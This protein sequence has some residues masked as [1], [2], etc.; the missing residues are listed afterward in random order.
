MKYKINLKAKNIELSKKPLSIYRLAQESDEKG[1]E[2][3]CMFYVNAS[4]FEH[5]DIST[6]DIYK[7]AID[8]K[9][10]VNTSFI[11]NLNRTDKKLKQDI[12][13][14]FSIAYL[15]SFY[16]ICDAITKKRNTTNEVL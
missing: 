6:L 1:F 2:L 9:N 16:K 12:Y 4:K 3:Y 15:D 11:M 13:S 5:S 14:I 7:T 8:E 10:T